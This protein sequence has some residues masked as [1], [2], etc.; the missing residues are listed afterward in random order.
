MGTLFDYVH[1][2]CNLSSLV[3]VATFFLY[4]FNTD[5]NLRTVNI[6][7]EMMRKF[8]EIALPNT[9][10]NLETCGVLAGK[11]VGIVE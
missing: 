7:L 6:P 5:C 1:V 2:K 11:L 4:S 9:D 8:I 10:Q 3:I